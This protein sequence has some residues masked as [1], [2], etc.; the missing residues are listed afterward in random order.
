MEYRRSPFVGSRSG[1][2]AT[3]QIK[4]T[5]APSAAAHA[6]VSV[7]TLHRGGKLLISGSGFTP[8]EVVLISYRG[9]LVKTAT[10]DHNGNVNKIAFT[11]P[12]NSPYGTSSITLKGA[13][14]ERTATVKVN[15]TPKPSIGIA[16]TP[17][18]VARGGALFVTGHGFAG[19]EIVLIYL[20][21]SLLQAPKAD[22]KGNFGKTKLTVPTN[23]AKGATV[24]LAKGARSGRTAQVN[25]VIT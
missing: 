12:S 23:M 24:V 18:K 22:S 20:H 8:R 2:Q 7:S 3:S 9:K 4:V 6:S 10:A 5:A 14:S 16:V 17:T 25:V 11:I 1:R 21:G 19:G 15:V 13:K